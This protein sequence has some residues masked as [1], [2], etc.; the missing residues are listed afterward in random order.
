MQARWDFAQL[1]DWSDYITA[2]RP[3]FSGLTE[4]DIDE[5]D[6][7]LVYGFQ[8]STSLR[9]AEARI[10]TLQLPCY[11]VAFVLAKPVMFRR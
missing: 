4:F 2:Q 6:N 5:R 8:D 10:A 1:Y 7:R 9:A 3:R 11:L